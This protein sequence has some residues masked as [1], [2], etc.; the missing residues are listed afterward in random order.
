MLRAQRNVVFNHPLAH[1]E[2]SFSTVNAIYQDRAGFVWLGTQNGLLRYDGTDAVVYRRIP[3]QEKG[4]KSNYIK[5][6]GEDLKGNIWIGTRDGLHVL[7]SSDG[8]IH[9]RIVVSGKENIES[10][11]RDL[12]GNMWIGGEFGL[13]RFSVSGTRTDFNIKDLFHDYTPIGKIIVDEKGHLFFE[14]LEAIYRIKPN[15]NVV[16]VYYKSAYLA[17]NRSSGNAAL[18]AKNSKI[19]FS[20]TGLSGIIEF[21][22]VRERIIRLPAREQESSFVSDICIDGFGQLWCGTRKG[23]W[24]GDLNGSNFKLYQH[25]SDDKK[26]LNSNNVHSFLID[27]EGR[28][29]MGTTAGAVNVVA[30]NQFSFDVL[31]V[32]AIKPLSSKVVWSI[33]Q[34]KYGSLWVGTAD[35][36]N[37][38]TLKKGS[39][40]I[41]ERIEK[42][43]VF[44]SPSDPVKLPNVAALMVVCHGDSV[45]VGT[46]AGLLIYNQRTQKS[47]VYRVPVTYGISEEVVYNVFRDHRGKIWAGT[48]KGLYFV[49]P[50][51]DT[52]SFAQEQNALFKEGIS[53]VFDIFEDS[54]QNLWL[55]T[56]RGVYQMDES[57]KV[58]MQM[59]NIPGDP[60]SLAENTIL[61]IN[62]DAKG[63]IWFGTM[64]GGLE[65]L[66]PGGKNFIHFDESRGFVH[67]IVLGILSDD[68][69]NIWVSGDKGITRVDE[70]LQLSAVYNP[71]NGM[72]IGDF[73][74]N[75]FYRAP[76]GRLFFGGE[77]LLSFNPAKLNAVISRPTL[78]I[79]GVEIN[80]EAPSATIRPELQ[81]YLYENSTVDLYNN[82]KQ[83]TIHFTGVEFLDRTN[84]IYEYRLEGF[85]PN[86]IPAGQKRSATYTN[87]PSGNYVFKIRTYNRLNPKQIAEIKLFVNVNPPFYF[88][89]WFISLVS[90]SLLSLLI[91]I[92]RYLSRL[93]LKRRLRELEIQQKLQN[94]RERISRELHD[95][96]GSGLTSMIMSIDN[97]R[98][99]LKNEGDAQQLHEIGSNARSTMQQL[100]E[101]IWALNKESLSSED[102]ISKVTDHMSKAI[103]A[104][105][106][107]TID[108]SGVEQLKLQPHVALNLYRILQEAVNNALKYA[109]ASQ[110]SVLLS[111]VD[112][113][114][115][116]SIV[117]NGKGFN[118]EE[119]SGGYG[120]N[121]MEVRAKELGGQL[122]LISGDAGTSVLVEF[123]D[124]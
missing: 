115:R 92:V 114:V 10:I 84:S 16:G 31:G 85:D 61:S 95:N 27:A 62:E 121:N 58:G 66:G 73:N 4:L 106:S 37:K 103:P 35:G 93:K 12:Q 74:Q 36:L 117:D 78:H 113:K 111:Q 109:E 80:Y 67:S 96:V 33:A 77:E 46:R 21:D 79:T 83:L 15:E 14:T 102:F 76:D 52:L 26:S 48:R 119:G 69:G 23:L 116:L 88:T 57:R 13:T 124:W 54:R 24:F 68:Q 50:G 32:S 82:D 47:Q 107:F 94:E 19:Y 9:H 53:T 22:G 38:I 91:V 123:N 71:E 42:I 2:Y 8:S 40:S 101:S 56:N 20:Y 6:L 87:L 118:V 59:K 1:S 5:S 64:G 17:K 65:M 30:P 122:S 44:K 51:Q 29:W 70:N 110:I 89:W 34:D 28:L 18:F 60:N 99:Q 120:L 86:W 25:I 100:R 49:K 63:R 55:G 41:S 98:R 7:N 39:T 75:A 3:G 97:T 45:I 104:S 108:T 105:I 90:I 43:E 72:S 112:K 11:C 81:R